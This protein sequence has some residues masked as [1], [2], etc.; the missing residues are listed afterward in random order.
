MEHLHESGTAESSVRVKFFTM[1]ASTN[2]IVK[3]IA[4]SIRRQD[5]QRDFVP[6]LSENMDTTLA[7]PTKL[8]AF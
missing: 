8:A 5:K 1:P 7:K 3:A 4:E 2:P 6:E